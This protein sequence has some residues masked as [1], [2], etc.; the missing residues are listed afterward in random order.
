MLLQHHCCQPSENNQRNVVVQEGRHHA[1]PYMIMLAINVETSGWPQR[2]VR[3]GRTRIAKRRSSAPPH[4]RPS[5]RHQACLISSPQRRIMSK[6]KAIRRMQMICRRPYIASSRYSSA[7][8]LRLW[9]GMQVNLLPRARVR[10][11]PRRPR[12]WRVCRPLC[13][14][15]LLSNAPLRHSLSPV[16]PQQQ[17]PRARVSVSDR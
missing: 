7:R 15:L 12:H 8:C 17:R 3:R 14:G 11:A 10:P 4:L 1:V 2:R 13:R 5:S 16:L 9:M 6:K